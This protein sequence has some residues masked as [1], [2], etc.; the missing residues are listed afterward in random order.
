MAKGLG[1]YAR[2]LQWLLHYYRGEH[3]VTVETANGLLSCSSKDWLIGKH[4]FTLR[5]YEFDFIRI[6]LE[7]LRSEGFLQPGR[8]NTVVDIGSNL[9]MICV[10]F[11]RENAFEKALAFEPSPE[12]FRLLQKNVDQNGLTD[13]ID[14]FPVALTSHD[15]EIG[16]EISEDNSGDSRVRQTSEKG[17]MNEHRRRTVS[18]PAKRFDTFLEENEIDPDQIDLLWM[19]VQGHE[20]HF[21]RGAENFLAR[22]AVPVI[23]EFWGYGIGRSG[24]SKQEYCDVVEKTFSK[25]F[26]LNGERYEPV[27]ISEIGRLFETHSRPREIASLLFI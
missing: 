6:S 26:V 13:R 24:M 22:G 8:N 19:D 2:R 21:F 14:C 10:A 1:Y 15:G 18:V 5:N 3:D 4:L 16:F 17:T 12:T 23:S 25:L 9:G 7:F 20:G 11:L 27:P